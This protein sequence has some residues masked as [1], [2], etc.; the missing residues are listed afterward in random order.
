MNKKNK[1]RDNLDN[2]DNQL[3]EL[4]KKIDELETG[5]QRTQADFAN[6]QK[7]SEEQKL[8]II[9]A[10]NTDLMLRLT[11][12]L[13][14]FRRA[15]THASDDKDPIFLGVKQIEKQLEDILTGEGLKKIEAA[16][17]TKFDPNLH[18]AISFEPNEKVKADHI[19]AEL[20]SGWMF[21]DK[22]L[23]PTKVRVSK[24]K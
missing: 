14:N 6:Y 23:K 12:V 18:E 20:E 4:K 22:V 13:D 21:R 24:G 17:G 19:I 7:R 3:I 1:K 8:N 2:P 15:F 16:S 5:W 10:A 11:P 9:A